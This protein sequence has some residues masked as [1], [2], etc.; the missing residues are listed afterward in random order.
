MCSGHRRPPANFYGFVRS[1]DE[2]SRE[3][4]DLHLP[5]LIVSLPFH[6]RAG[7]DFSF[8]RP[9]SRYPPSSHLDTKAVKKEKGNS[10]ISEYPTE[11]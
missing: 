10:A 5:S 6:E 7:T 2:R 1:I 9:S 8:L 11:L 3:E 4:I